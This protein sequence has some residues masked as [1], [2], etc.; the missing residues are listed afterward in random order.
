MN[1]IIWKFF[2]AFV[3]L[4]LIVV[5]VLYFFVSLKLQDNFEEK[6]TEE[7]RSNAVL[8]GDILSGDLLERKNEAI[9]KKIETLAEK[10]DLRITVVDKQDK[11]VDLFGGSGSTLIACEKTNRKCFMMELDS[12]YCDVIIARYINYTGNNKIKV[13]GKEV[14][15]ETS[16]ENK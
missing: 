2:G 15:W 8:V 12:H 13:N 3:F 14:T 5:F 1:K 4:T 9:Q 6:I 7:L 10:L 16:K 11:V